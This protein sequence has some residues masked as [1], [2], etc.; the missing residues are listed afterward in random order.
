MS[1]VTA[2]E[3]TRHSDEPD[4]YDDGMTVKKFTVSI[5]E[6]L[7]EDLR[8]EARAQRTTVSSWVADAVEHQLGLRAMD[9]GI[10]EYEAEHG[11]ITEDE[12]AE[13]KAEIDAA[14]VRSRAKAAARGQRAV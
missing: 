10:A 1:V 7:Y 6:E 5:P 3:M 4:R 13:T 2:E 14:L 8:R 11:L 9:E 12:L